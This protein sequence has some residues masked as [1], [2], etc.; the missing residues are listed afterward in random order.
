MSENTR[1]DNFIS[2]NKEGIYSLVGYMALYCSGAIYGMAHF[3][4][5][6]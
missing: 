6:P 5:V 3:K 2:A 1:R 4:K